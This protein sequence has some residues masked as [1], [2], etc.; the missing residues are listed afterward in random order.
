[1]KGLRVLPYLLEFLKA[2]AFMIINATILHFTYYDKGYILALLREI[3]D[4]K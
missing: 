2:H 1:M 4:F 3:L